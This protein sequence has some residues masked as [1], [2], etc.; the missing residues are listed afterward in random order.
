MFE[1]RQTKL[2]KLKIIEL[3][4]SAVD[5]KIFMIFHS[6][7]NERYPMKISIYRFFYKFQIE[8]W[9]AY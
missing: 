4:S 3:F 8:K 7:K 5:I 1:K 9:N 6:I 2:K